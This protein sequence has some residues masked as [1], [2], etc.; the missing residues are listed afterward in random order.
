MPREE[1]GCILMNKG[2]GAKVKYV[3][4]IIYLIGFMG[5]GKT[6]IGKI[7]AQR[8]NRFWA[9]TDAVIEEE[10]G[11]SVEEI[12]AQKGEEYFRNLE[13]QIVAK[14]SEQASAIISCGGGLV[15]R[16]ENLKLMRS[17]GCVVYLRATADTLIKRLQNDECRP[18][19]NRKG[20]TL[21]ERI[22]ELL[23]KRVS[24]YESVADII[25]DTDSK[26]PIEIAEELIKK[27]G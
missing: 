15:L 4:D 5:A 13:T 27:L 19:L 18:L 21:E 7:C 14:L 22:S 23:E 25:I 6:T 3:K 17:K 11:Q 1:N 26:L 10:V 8:L 24:Y 16:E 2:K 12:F 9:D 20:E